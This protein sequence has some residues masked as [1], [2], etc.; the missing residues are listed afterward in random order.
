MSQG[1]PAKCTAMMALV[2]GV[3]AA[4]TVSAVMFWLLAQTSAKTGVAPAVTILEADARKV[5]E[6]TM[7]S[8]PAP[9]FNPFKMTSSAN[10]PLATA[11]PWAA[12]AH[13]ANSF[14]NSRHSEP[15]Q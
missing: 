5:R 13:A 15:V 8:S 4:R 12:S 2:R 9:M 14:S 1:Q 3:S 10:V 6:V 11:R 7:T